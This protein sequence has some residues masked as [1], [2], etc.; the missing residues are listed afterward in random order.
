MIV[1][2]IAMDEYG[3]CASITRADTLDECIENCIKHYGCEKRPETAES[4]K[5]KGLSII[6]YTPVWG[7]MDKD[8]DDCN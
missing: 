4:L 6:E 5:A 8:D 3:G 2:Y 7:W 1:R